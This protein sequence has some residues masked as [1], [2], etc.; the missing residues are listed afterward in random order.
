MNAKNE[1]GAFGACVGDSDA[2]GLRGQQTGVGESCQIAVEM[3]S[4][5]SRCQHMRHK[6]M[7]LAGKIF[8]GE[9]ATGCR[10]A[11]QHDIAH[12]L[13]IECGC[14]WFGRRGDNFMGLTQHDVTVLEQG[15]RANRPGM[16]EWSQIRQRT[17][18]ANHQLAT[19]Y[20]P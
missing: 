6:R 2:Y 17:G 5:G 10:H 7:Q 14:A 19:P 1:G 9:R 18:R 16:P 3:M 8:A 20:V 13:D 15:R 11:H 12:P 4:P